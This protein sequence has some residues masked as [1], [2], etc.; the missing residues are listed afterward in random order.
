MGALFL[1][2]FN[3]VIT[4]HFQGFIFFVKLL[5]CIQMFVC[6]PCYSEEPNP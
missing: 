1:F 2:F 6:I 3:L 5:V 4:F